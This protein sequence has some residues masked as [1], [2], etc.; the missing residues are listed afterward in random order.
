MRPR[1]QNVRSTAE[2]QGWRQP[3]LGPQESQPSECDLD[4]GLCLTG[5]CSSSIQDT[6]SDTP[7]QRA[8]WMKR[9]LGG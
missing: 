8:A 1:D 6:G 9:P 5:A 4:V 7:H 2:N 3:L